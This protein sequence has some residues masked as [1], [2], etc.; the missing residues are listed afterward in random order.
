MSC[1]TYQNEKGF[2]KINFISITLG[3]GKVVKQVLSF[4]K[5][6]W[7]FLLLMDLKMS[8]PSDPLNSFLG[9]N[10]KENQKET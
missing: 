8:T 10:L 6:T 9:I 4:W 3:A 2:L 7:Q 5:A 1:F